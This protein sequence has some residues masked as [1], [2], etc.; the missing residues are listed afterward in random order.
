MKRKNTARN[1][2]FTSIISLLLC[3]T[4]LVGATFAWFTDKV[5][6]GINTI[7][8]GNLDVE[9]YH[10]DKN[11][12]GYVG[13][14]TKLF[15]DVTLW[16]PG[17]VVYEN[18]VVENKGSLALKYQLSIN[19]ENETVVDGHG[20]SEV[21]K[22]AVVEGGFTGDR[23][24]AKKLD[25]VPM[26]SFVL[27]G[28]LEG[29]TTSK[30]YGIVI[31]WQP[32]ANDNLFNMNNDNQGKTLTIDLGVNLFATQEMYEEDSFG[33]DYDKDAWMDGMKVY[34]AQDLQAAINNGEKDLVLMEDIDLSESLVIPAN[35]TYSLRAVSNGIVINLNGK[36]IRST[37]LNAEGK[38]AHAVVNNGNLLLANGTITVSGENGGSAI[39]NAEGA[40]L[41]IQD[42]TIVGAPQSGN[43]YPSYAINSYGELTVESADVSSTHGAIALFGDTVINDATVV[44]NGF[45]GSSHV[46]YIG[47]EGTDVVIND[48]SYTHNGNADGS[49]AYIMTGATVTVNGGTFSASNGGYGMATYTGSL[50]VKG[51]TFANAFLDWGG[52]ISISGGTFAKEPGSKYIAEGYKAV[53][54]DDGTYTVLFPQESFDSLIDAAQPGDT[55]QIPAGEYTFPASKLE[56][57][58]TLECAPGTVF[59]GTSKLNINGAT[60]IGATFS[61]PGGTAADQTINGTFKNCTFT[62]KNGLRWCYAGDTVVFENCVFDGSVY[63][64]HFDGGANEVIFKDCTISGF[65][66]MG[67]AITMLKMEGCTFKPGRSGYNGINL[68]GSVEMTDCT[69]LFDGT[70]TEWVDLCGDNTTAT[71]TNCVVTDGTTIKGIETVVGNYGTGNTITINGEV[72]GLVSDVESLKDALNNGGDVTLTG[73]VKVDTAANAESNAYGKTGLNVT[74]GQTI[75]GNGMTLSVSGATGTWDSAVS[76]TGGTIKNLTIDSGFRGVFVNHNS[77][78]SGKVYLE[79]VIIDGPTYTISCDQGTGNGLEATNCTFNGWTSYATTIGDVKFVDC[80]FGEGAGYKFCRPYAATA[81]VGCDFAEGFQID[82]RAAVSFENCTINGVALTA[83]NLSELVIGNLDNVT[84]K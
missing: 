70:K 43:G 72:L 47:G 21:L 38:K 5:E 39:Y 48:G 8:A 62:G 6:S 16:E 81:F 25:L 18:F 7:A 83:E 31:Y 58:M 29:N 73:D 34:T 61:N 64:V 41:T 22:V 57:G 78:V 9:L 76:I 65:N 24:D 17:A 12:S 67:G 49:L 68:W 27:P 15:N 44:M 3:V 45:G 40:A 11:D 56:A 82:P 80:S 55:V 74:N 36:T 28:A 20:L 50:I 33:E 59:E 14:S 84:L 13:T 60:V 53:A 63:G 66:A 77:T 37:G 54:N 69:F 23:E 10:S 2:L 71:F 1:A 51:G 35:T 26:K 46:F 30:T 75:D 79:N 42:M 19:F 32:T 52:P 4:M